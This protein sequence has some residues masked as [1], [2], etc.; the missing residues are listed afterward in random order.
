[1]VGKVEYNS[2][3]NHRPLYKLIHFEG[4]Q[5]YAVEMIEMMVVF[6]NHF[7]DDSREPGDTSCALFALTKEEFA[8]KDR[9]INALDQVIDHLYNRIP[10]DRLIEAY[11]LSFSK[12]THVAQ[13][14]PMKLLIMGF[15]KIK[16]M[17]YMNFYLDRISQ[18]WIFV[19]LRWL[20]VSHQK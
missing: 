6:D 3:L 20:D 4:P 9:D 5:I 11:Y 2:P 19:L 8:L 16:Y 15:S 13:K 12:D 1:M 18:S 10:E 17:P 7:T 14:K